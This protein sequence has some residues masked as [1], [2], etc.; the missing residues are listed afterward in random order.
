MSDEGASS[1]D[2]KGKSKCESRGKKHR[3]DLGAKKKPT[4]H[5]VGILDLQAM[6]INQARN[7]RLRFSKLYISGLGTLCSC[8]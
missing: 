4:R 2:R 3:R 1:G 5:Y 8:T 6:K 7:C